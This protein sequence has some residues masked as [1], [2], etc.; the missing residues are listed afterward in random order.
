MLLLKETG[1][2][3]Q[4]RAG[5][6]L[7]KNVLFPALKEATCW[8]WWTLQ[9][10]YCLMLDFTWEPSSPCF[11]KTWCK[12]QPYPVRQ[13]SLGLHI[14]SVAA[15]CPFPVVPVLYFIHFIW[16]PSVFSHLHVATTISF[17]DTVVQPCSEHGGEEEGKFSSSTG[18]GFGFSPSLG[19][20]D[21]HQAV[22]QC[23][24]TAVILS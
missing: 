9:E 8:I 2:V 13:P 11:F 24:G 23:Q 15:A 7:R 19:G 18:V 22:Q 10:S 12:F 1:C 6:D 3:W 21:R 4:R 14:P 17:G 5:R 20:N 16:M